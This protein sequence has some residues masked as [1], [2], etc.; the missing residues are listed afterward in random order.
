M[1]YTICIV[2]HVVERFKTVPGPFGQSRVVENTPVLP[3]NITYKPETFDPFSADEGNRKILLTDPQGTTTSAEIFA[4]FPAI[5]EPKEKEI[6]LEGG[7][8]LEALAAPYGPEERESWA[9]Q[10]REAR[11]WLVDNTA[12]TPMLSAM[13]TA[14]GI[15]LAVMVGKVMENVALFEAAAGQILGQQQALLDQVYA[16]TDFDIMWAT[17]WPKI[18]T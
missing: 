8:R 1:P 15:T 11:A 10:Q 2:P 16:V 14:R 17:A 4:T 7:K 9:T 12:A 18:A 6:R 13:A 3:G 5:R